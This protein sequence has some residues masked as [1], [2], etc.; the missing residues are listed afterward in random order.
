VGV[1]PAL[2]GTEMSGSTAKKR[3][4]R[5]PVGSTIWSAKNRVSRKRHG[6]RRSRSLLVTL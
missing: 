6:E 1:L 3:N 4:D 2:K 5:G